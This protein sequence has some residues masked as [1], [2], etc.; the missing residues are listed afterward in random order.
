MHEY[1]LYTRDG[2]GVLFDFFRKE[3]FENFSFE[4]MS[5]GL[6]RTLVRAVKWSEYCL[7]QQWCHQGNTIPTCLITQIKKRVHQTPEGEWWVM[8]PH[9][10]CFELK[11]TTL[12]VESWERFWIV[13]ELDFSSPY[14]NAVCVPIT[15]WLWGYG[16]LLIFYILVNQNKS[17]T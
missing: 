15:N 5:D 12:C 10:H 13:V 9:G 14:C 8:K 6:E 1:H 11:V 7:R 4:P 3:H 17:V 16:T 2:I